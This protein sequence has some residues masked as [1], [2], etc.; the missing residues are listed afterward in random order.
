MTTSIQLYRVHDL[1]S[2]ISGEEAFLHFLE[3]LEETF[4]RY[5]IHS[6]VSSIFNYTAMCFPSQQG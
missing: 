3:M 4:S 2:T 6:G 5:Y 1:S